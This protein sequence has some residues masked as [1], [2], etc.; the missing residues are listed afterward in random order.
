[1]VRMNLSDL[2]ILKIKGSHYFCVISRISGKSEATNLM[3][4]TDLTK[5]SGTI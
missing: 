5:N 4:N 1:M 3:Q 2:A